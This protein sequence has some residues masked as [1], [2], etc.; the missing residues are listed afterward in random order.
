[1]AALIGGIDWSAG[2]IGVGASTMGQLAGHPS[3]GK[4]ERKTKYSSPHNLPQALT[5]GTELF[6]RAYQKGI[7]TVN[8]NR[9]F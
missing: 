5:K 7:L 2:S 3:V 4:T 1:M 8:F 6:K 9:A